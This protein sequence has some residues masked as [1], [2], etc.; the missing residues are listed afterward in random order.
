MCG[1]YAVF[2]PPSKLK[3]L[4]G[5]ENLPNF[6]PRYNAAP[7][8][9]L[10]VI[11]KHRMGMARWGFVPPWAKEDDKSMAAKM[12][13]AR[14]ETVS[15]KPSFR[16]SWHKARR[17]LVPVNGFYEWQKD[18]KSGGKQAVFIHDPARECMALAGL[19]AKNGDLVTFTML[20]KP[21][22]GA[23]R[24]I[25]HRM[26]VIIDPA[27]AGEWFAADERGVRAM[28]DSASAHHLHFHAVDNRVGK[29]ANDDENLIAV[30]DPGPAPVSAGS[31]V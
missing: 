2:T 24:H 30:I 12:I 9:E 27:Q 5:T 26:P 29:V 3:D 23:I 13:N 15:E 14:S 18:E 10:P 7:L 6:P 16:D 31:L 28:I 8:Q 4:F 25:H 1:R 17:C 19:W 11:I 22:D 20:T 21:A